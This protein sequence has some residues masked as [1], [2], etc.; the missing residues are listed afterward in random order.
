[1]QKTHVINILGGS[2]IGKSTTAA[3]L[4]GEMKLSGYHVELVREYVKNWMWEKR[5]VGFFDQ[6]Y[7]SAQQ[8]KAE[9]NLYGE[10]DFIV[11]DSPMLL[12]PI[13]EEHYSPPGTIRTAVVSHMK[14]AESIG[15]VYHNFVLQRNKEFDTRGRRE[16]LDEAKAID[17]KVIDFLEQNNL[18]YNYIDLD[19]RERVKY[20]L[21][22]VESL[23]INNKSVSMGDN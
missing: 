9:Y 7:I 4:Y 15:V 19:D 2:G 16:T 5:Q 8:A 12:A 10:V 14:K 6:L 17:E 3:L 20:L 1:M 18:S 23:G 22:F 21:S 13:Y 11:T